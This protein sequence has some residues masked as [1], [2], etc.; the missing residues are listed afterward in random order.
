MIMLSLVFAL[1]TV[2]IYLCTW[3]LHQVSRALVA[4]S[5]FVGL[6]GGTVALRFY[7]GDRAICARTVYMN[8]AVGP[9]E[10]CD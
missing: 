5:V 4:L 8:G 6:V 9:L 2:V 7:I 3:R 1:I 10:N